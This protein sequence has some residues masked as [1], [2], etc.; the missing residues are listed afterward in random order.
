MCCIYTACV[1]Q[2][3]C[4][5]TML[6]ASLAE[7]RTVKL[8]GL[9]GG[10][11]TSKPEDVVKVGEEVFVRMPPHNKTLCSLVMANNENSPDGKRIKP[12][13]Y[14][15]LANNK[16]LQSLIACRNRTQAQALADSAELQCS[17]FEQPAAKK[18]RRTKAE[19]ARMR[20]APEV[21]EIEVDVDGTT[22][23]LRVLR[24][25]HPTDNLMVA[26][27]AHT[28]Q[29]VLHILRAASY[30]EGRAPRCDNLPQGVHVRKA[31]GFLC[32]YKKDQGC[33][34]K[35]VYDLESALAFH[36]DPGAFVELVDHTMADGDAPLEGFEEAVH[37]APEHE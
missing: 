15:T 32:K 12:Q 14:A 16:G 4:F 28:I 37:D 9:K 19:A 20:Q 36:A 24:P 2:G 26:Y 31:G 25:V 6:A 23:S 8:D 35:L 30:D 22:H 13:D 27:E 21:V 3:I 11:V 5:A 10:W 7:V 29:C 17:L 34:Y 18:A 33:A 1:T